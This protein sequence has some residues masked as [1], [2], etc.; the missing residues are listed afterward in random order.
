MSTPLYAIKA[1]NKIFKT[2]SDVSSKIKSVKNK[3]IKGSKMG[4][5]FSAYKGSFLKDVAKSFRSEGRMLKKAAK[6]TPKFVY[7]N[8]FTS[9]VIAGGAINIG[10]NYG[11]EKK[12]K[13]KG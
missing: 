2:G 1:M 6:A 4:K 5:E 7:D 13:K 8:P 10:M 3:Y 9:G 11:K 12:N